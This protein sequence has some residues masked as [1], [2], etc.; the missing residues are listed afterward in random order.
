MVE[1]QLRL[2]HFQSWGVHSE[3]K[4]SA[5]CKGLHFEIDRLT[6]VDDFSAVYPLGIG[7][8]KLKKQWQIHRLRSACLA[9]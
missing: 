2:K 7:G 8:G 4:L 6:K 9:C 3:Q 5:H 1:L